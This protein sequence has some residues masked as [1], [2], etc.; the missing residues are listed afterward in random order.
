[1][2]IAAG[3]HLISALI[4]ACDKHDRLTQSEVVMLCTGLPIAGR[5]TTASQISNFELT[6]LEHPDQ[7]RKQHADLTRSRALSKSS[8]GSSRLTP[9]Q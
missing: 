2:R 9:A 7:M 1:M 8:W 5:A 4:E 6:L 3:R